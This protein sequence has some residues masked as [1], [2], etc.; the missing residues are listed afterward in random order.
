MD[1]PLW[2]VEQAALEMKCPTSTMYRYFRSI[3]NAGL[4]VRA[5]GSRYVLGP[6]IIAMDRQTRHFDPLI[7]AATLPMQNL[8]DDLPLNCVTLLCRLYH[9]KV[10]CTYQV[11]PPSANIVQ[12]Y[13]RGSLLPLLRGACS[14]AISSYLP[15]RSLRRFFEDK[16]SLDEIEQKLDWDALRR[17]MRDIRKDKLAITRGELVNGFMAIASPIT[18]TE[19]EVFASIGIVLDRTDISPDAQAML[20]ARVR[21]ATDATSQN[22]KLLS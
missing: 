3:V 13:E 9:S 12:Y 11:S 15:T 5:D 14:L 1:A 7:K 22:L 19:G 2:T 20:S 8:V 6:A 4:L 21:A 10:I 18:G 16:S 17:R